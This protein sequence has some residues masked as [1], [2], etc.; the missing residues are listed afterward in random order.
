MKPK[1]SARHYESNPKASLQLLPEENA[2]LVHSH[3]RA[4][5]HAENNLYG[6]G[7]LMFKTQQLPLSSMAVT[8][9]YPENTR[10]KYL[11]SSNCTPF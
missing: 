8:E 7:F 4:P 1:V 10:N 9:Y 5:L 3:H 2:G 6:S 11:I